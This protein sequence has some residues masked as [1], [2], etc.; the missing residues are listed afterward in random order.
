MSS[1]QFSHSVMSDSMQ[2]HNHSMPGLP[3]HHQHPEFTQIHVHRVGNAIQ[4]TYPL[5]SPSPPAPNPSQHQGLSS[6]LSYEI[7][8][9]Q[10]SNSCLLHWQADSLLLSHQGS[11]KGCLEIFQG[12]NLGLPH[13]VKASLVAQTV[14]E[15][16][17]NTGDLGSIPGS[18]RSPGKKWQPI[19]VFL[20]R[21]SHGQRSLEGYSLWGCKES[22]MTERLTLR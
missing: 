1:V 17:C 7:F 21:E 9:D 6:S 15:S 19:L 4:P 13:Q 12:Q 3:V 16:V 2:P 10:G 14:K 22:D 20:P 5:S 18:G 8:P 11:P